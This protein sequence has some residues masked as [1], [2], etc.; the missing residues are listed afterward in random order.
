M[1]LPSETAQLPGADSTKGNVLRGQLGTDTLRTISSYIWYIYLA[2]LS[3][4]IFMVI[5]SN[6]QKGSRLSESSI[7]ELNYGSTI[8]LS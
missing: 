8:V 1:T 7:K 3:P 2:H 4:T 5:D 6:F